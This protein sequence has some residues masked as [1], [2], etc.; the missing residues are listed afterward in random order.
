M[1]IILDTNI[2]FSALLNSNGTIGDI[3]FES[4]NA[5]KFYSCDYMRYEIEKHWEKLKKI[6]KLSEKDLQE[7]LFRL[8]TKIHFIDENLIPQKIWV[9]AEKITSDIDIDDVD[10]IAL[11]DYLKGVLWTG[12]KILYNGLIKKEYNKVISTK[13]LLTIRDTKNKKYGY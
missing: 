1:K 9:R 7:S 4:E 5:F 8:F 3:I 6:S 2:I 13:E 10:F 12:D 11:T